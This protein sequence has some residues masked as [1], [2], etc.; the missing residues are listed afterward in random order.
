MGSASEGSTRYEEIDAKTIIRKSRVVDPWFIG[1]YG[2][3]L[4]R[5]CQ[6][7]CL[8]C[9]GR[10]ERYYVPGDFAREIA[11]KRNARP[12]L[13]REVARLK[14][15][16]FLFIGGGVSDAYQPAEDE[17]R[18]SRGALELAIEHGL[19]VHVLTKSATVRRD[20]G[21]IEAIHGDS[22]A[23]VS[24]SIHTLDE[25]VRA[26]FEPGASPIDER[27]EVLAEAKRLGFGTGVMALPVLPGISDQ[28]EAI[29]A[30]VGR[31]AEVGVDFV[32]FGGLTLR[33]GR[34]KDLYLSVIDRFYPEHRAGYDLVY[35]C[36]KPS[37]MA[38]PRYYARVDSR[39][40]EAARAHDMPNRAPRRL[41]T[42]LVPKYAELGVLLEHDEQAHWLR[43]GDK[44]G[45]G[46]ARSGFALQE[47]ARQRLAKHGRKKGFDWRTVDGEMEEMVASDTL[48]DVEGVTRAAAE[49]MVE[50][51]TA[52]DVGRRDGSP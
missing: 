24:C 15:P 38:D 41:F 19:P 27:F 49:R 30:L 13:E 37:G 46:L 1:R 4:Y 7:G 23:I 52:T 45:G 36:N 25:T 32:C 14:E 21:L 48:S 34:Q 6:H 16:G 2:M 12:V 35:R 31:A 33:P 44:P 28:P 3:N 22:R 51:L 9:D 8:Y 18:L 42:G 26:R 5:G 20:F 47:W 10:A 17:Y 50:L 29:R 40:A 11:V 43:T 39:F